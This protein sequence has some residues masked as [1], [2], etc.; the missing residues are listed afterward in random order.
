MSPLLSGMK[1]LLYNSG[2]LPSSE[3]QYF[4]YNYGDFRRTTLVGGIS[5]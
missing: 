4:L 3:Q 1:N 2:D 5:G